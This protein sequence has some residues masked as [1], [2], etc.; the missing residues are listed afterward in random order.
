VQ[1][2]VADQGFGFITGDD[3]QVFFLH[4]GALKELDW[5][6]IAEG[7][8]GEFEDGG[9]EHG[10]RPSERHRAANVRLAPDELPAADHELLP[11]E[12]LGRAAPRQ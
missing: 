12:K 7:T 4:R 2:L 1:S 3:G 8:R 9:L 6:E 11:P 10:D 5:G